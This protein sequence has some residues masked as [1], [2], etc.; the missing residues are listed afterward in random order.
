M[1]PHSVLMTALA[2]LGGAVTVR[3]A[4]LSTPAMYVA[5]TQSIYCIATNGG[6]KPAEVAVTVRNTSGGIVSNVTSTCPAQL[7][8]FASCVV[9]VPAD[10]D[11]ACFFDVGG[12]IRASI[13]LVANNQIQSSLPATR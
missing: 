8:P 13:N 9:V 6:S 1:L 10:T 11:A 2:V 3:A 5:G 12:K 7:Q 4:E